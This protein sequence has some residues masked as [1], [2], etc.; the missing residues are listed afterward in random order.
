MEEGGGGW[1]RVGEDEDEDGLEVC[2]VMC[3]LWRGAGSCKSGSSGNSVSMTNFSMARSL[4]MG[5]GRS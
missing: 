4:V 2:S 3:V 5:D 1:F